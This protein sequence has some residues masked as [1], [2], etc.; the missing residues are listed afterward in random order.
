MKNIT[1]RRVALILSV[2]IVGIV[3]F[4]VGYS[5]GALSVADFLI[6][7]AVNM[8]IVDDISKVELMEYYI[9]LKGGV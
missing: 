4:G 6:E 3:A 5:I 1:W 9:K 2:V 7:K 8:G